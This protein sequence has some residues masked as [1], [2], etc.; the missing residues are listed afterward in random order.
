MTELVEMSVI[1][2][3]IIFLACKGRVPLD[4][5]W[6]DVILR[7]AKRAANGGC[8]HLNIT[9]RGTGSCLRTFR[10]GY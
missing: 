7:F 1:I 2:A 8:T 4:I 3:A 5:D 6:S 9:D 10:K